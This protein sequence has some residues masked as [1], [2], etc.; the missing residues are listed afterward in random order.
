[1]ARSVHGRTLPKTPEFD[2]VA[3]RVAVRTLPGYGPKYSELEGN[4]T[5]SGVS[6][7]QSQYRAPS[8]PRTS[9][10]IFEAALRRA[11]ALRVLRESAG[12]AVCS[13]ALGP[14]ARPAPS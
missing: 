10:V 9:G 12:L 3:V 6:L 4:S 11:C 5:S 1:M 14:V 2:R 8:I 7:V 13:P